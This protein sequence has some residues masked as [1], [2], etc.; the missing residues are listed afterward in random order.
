MA[1][2]FLTNEDKQELQ[3]EIQ[4]VVDTIGGVIGAEPELVDIKGYGTP[5]YPGGGSV[6][7]GYI[8]ADGNITQSA[9]WEAY[10]FDLS[11]VTPKRYEAYTNQLAMRAIGFYNSLD[12]FSSS[13]FVG[14]VEFTTISGKSIIENIEIPEGAVC[15]VFSNRSGTATDIVIDG[16]VNGDGGI[17]EPIIDQIRNLE[18]EVE[19]LR[20]DVGKTS[21]PDP[22]EVDLLTSENLFGNGQCYMSRTGALTSTASWRTY[23]VKPEYDKIVFTGYCPTWDAT[24]LVGFYSSENPSESTFIRGIVMPNTT[25]FHEVTV[26]RDD[27]P[28]GTKLILFSSRTASGNGTALV[29]TY[30]P[31]TEFDELREI[32]NELENE[33]RGKGNVKAIFANIPNSNDFTVIKDEIWFAQNIYENGVATEYTTIHRYRIED[34]K[35]VHLS[36]IDSD[37]GHWNTVDY[38][39]END[40]LIFTN[41]ANL[42][43]TEGNYFTVVKNPLALGTVA[44]IADCGIKYNT[45]YGFKIQAVWGDDNFGE[46]NVV[47]LTSNYTANIYK[48]LLVRGADGEFAKDGNGYGSFVEL[49]TATNPTGIGTGGGDFWGD[50]LYIGNGGGYGHY[51]M[52]MSDYSTKKIT[53]RFYYDDGTA[54]SGSTQGIHVDSR[55]LWVFYNIA[56]LTD[57][58][59]IQYYR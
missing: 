43:T 26:T 54:Y 50:T 53:K 15:A 29:G 46:H 21:E 47:Y 6:Y 22:V 7:G 13:T 45:N 23:A 32:V 14:G 38:C 34:G 57:N 44:R 25:D 1:I 2:T 24:P 33:N 30:T 55:Y 59:L 11:V 51:E 52:S 49:E 48:V 42:E 41:A 8:S 16:F 40:C 18:A 28:E 37:F 56:G 31:P 58:F 10:A 19:Q 27:I 12:E 39:E 36:D 9:T 4:T 35:L 3:G 20:D 5:Y 17:D